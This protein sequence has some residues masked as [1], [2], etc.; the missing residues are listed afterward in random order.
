M[1]GSGM[2]RF[3]FLKVLI[4][5][6]LLFAAPA[7]SQ[8]WTSLKEASRN[9]RSVKADFLQKRF[10]QILTKPLLSEG[11]LF[12]YTSN[13]LRPRQIETELSHDVLNPAHVPL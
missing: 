10:L 8:D 5:T 9:I 1:K 11:K 12:F 2:K 3:L 7:L 4:T 6:V 13:L